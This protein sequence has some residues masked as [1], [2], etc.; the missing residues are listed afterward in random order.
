MPELCRSII[1]EAQDQAEYHENDG[2]DDPF[3]FLIHCESPVLRRVLYAKIRKRRMDAK[4]N[5]RPVL[6]PFPTNK[7]VVTMPKM[8]KK[9]VGRRLLTVKRA[10]C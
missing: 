10:G 9:R 2:R 6:V 5:G 1:V 3:L 8:P 4:P 7:S